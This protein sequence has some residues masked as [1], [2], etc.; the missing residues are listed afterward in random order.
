MFPR[1]LVSSVWRQVTFFG[2]LAVFALALRAEE[3]RPAY[4]DPAVPLEE[5]VRDLIARLTLEEKASLLVSTSPGVERLGIPKYDWWN[6]ALHGVARA[7]EA[8]VYPQ[9]I[10]LAAMWDEPFMRELAHAIGIEGRAK[11]HEAK[12]TGTAGRRYTGLTFWSPNINIFRDP[13]W[14][15]GQETY[16]EDPFLTA[17]TGVAFVRGLQ[18]DDRDRLLAAACAKHF[19]VHSGPEPKRHDFDAVPGEPDLHDT[20]LPAFEALVREAQVESVMMAYNAID[21]EPCSINS[22][23]YDLLYNRWDFDGHVVSDCWSINDLF[24]SYKRAAN[25]QEAE[26]LSVN[27]GLCLRC[28]DE[29]TELALAVAS[30]LITEEVLDH[31]LH[32]LLRTM[33]RLGFFDPEEAVPFASIPYSRNNSPEHAALALRAAHESVVL[34]RNDGLLPLDARKLATVAV[35]GPNADSVSALLG[36]YNGTPTAPVT[37][38]A[39]LRAALEPGVRVITAPGCDYV[40]APE[41]F[42]PIPRSA[43]RHGSAGGLLGRIYRNEDFSGEPSFTDHM[44]PI[45]FDWT[46]QAWGQGTFSTRW[47]GDITARFAGDYTFELAGHGPFRLFADG[48]LVIDAWDSTGDASRTFRRTL[49]PGEALPVRIEY[50]HTD[51]PTRLA[52]RWSG[53]PADAG[54]ADAVAAARRADVVVFVGGISPELEGEEMPVDYEGFAGGD[55]TRIELPEIQERLLKELHALGK[56]VVFVS[57]SGSAIAFPWADDHVP[58]ILQAWYPGQAGGTAVADLL[59]GRVN[60]SGR[61]PVTFY[62]S[63]T[64]LPGFEDYRM[65]GRTYRYFRGRPLYAFGHGLSYTTFSYGP[66]ALERMEP[67]D[68]DAPGATLLRARIVITNTGTRP[69][70]EVVQLYAREPSDSGARALQSLCGFARAE[71][72]P[73]QAVTVTIDIPAAALRRW[74]AGDPHGIPPGDWEIAAGASSADLRSRTAIRIE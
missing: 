1:S 39:G 61:L 51:G 66:L 33:F 69:G 73:G 32:R 41:G 71:L 17:R 70:T 38:L 48:E 25:M 19:A 29:P 31:Q 40:A 10:A 74:S 36:N 43:M 27:A 9:A 12:R 44:G 57:M 64:D 18:G 26:A 2:A 35:I 5:R 52:F 45:A 3:E 63:T 34:L 55:R 67:D 21:G 13:R 24:T 7:G 14:G 58:A 20:Y 42:S 4:R 59:L 22:R 56:P 62:R 37:I 53:P 72:A 6:E 16:G 65:D 23:L 15:R 28:G 68:A 50:K 49:A 54:F 60:P 47:E 8:T 11:H 30:G 46:G